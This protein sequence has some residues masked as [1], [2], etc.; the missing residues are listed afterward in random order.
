[1]NFYVLGFGKPQD[2]ALQ[3]LRLAESKNVKVHLPTDTVIADS[4]SNEAETKISP[5]NSIPDGWMGLDAGPETNQAF[6]EVISQSKTILWNGPVGV[7]EMDNFAQGTIKLGLA[8][9]EATENGAFSLVGGG[10][11]VAAAK[12]FQLDDK[13]SYVSTGGGAMLEMLEGKTLPG[14]EALLK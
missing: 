8:I 2:M 13:V 3:I 14:I 9:A 12:K 4:F 11:S 6:S 7:F 1:M 5:V 10:D